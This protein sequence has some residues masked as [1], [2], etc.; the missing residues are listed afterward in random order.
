VIETMVAVSL[1]AVAVVALIGLYPAS[2]RASRQAHGHLVAANLA[3]REIEFSRAMAW[4]AVEDRNKDYDLLLETN[5]APTT[6]EFETSIR[7]TMVSDGLKRIHVTVRWN[8]TDRMS[9]K[10]EMETYVAKLVP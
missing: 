10:L 4:D 2:V 7:V 8:G 6:V 1:F 9:R 5:G 3:E